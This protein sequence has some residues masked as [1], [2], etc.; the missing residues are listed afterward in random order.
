MVLVLLFRQKKGKFQSQPFFED[1]W[2]FKT[3]WTNPQDGWTDEKRKLRVTEHFNTIQQSS[4]MQAF[5]KL[6]YMKTKIPDK[7]HQKILQH[8]KQKHVSTEDCSSLKGFTNCELINSNGTLGKKEHK[9]YH[10]SIL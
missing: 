7:I 3:N 1:L 10:F 4:A 9:Y 6:G 2:G 8:K 5:T